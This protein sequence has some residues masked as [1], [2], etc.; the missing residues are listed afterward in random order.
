[1]DA[2]EEGGEFAPEGIVLGGRERGHDGVPVFAFDEFTEDGV[3]GTDRMGEIRSE[4]AGE[5]FGDGGEPRREIVFAAEEV[6]LDVEEERV[7]GRW[8]DA[9]DRAV[10][11]G[12]GEAEGVV[13]GAAAEFDG[14]G[15]HGVGSEQACG[16]G[17]DFR[18]GGRLLEIGREAGDKAEHDRGQKTGD[19]GRNLNHQ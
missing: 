4:G 14:F 17:G 1:V 18:G 3:A 5:K 13:E 10:S 6:V 11:V 8:G 2:A 15:E 7:R 16:E 12:G 9:Q 19:G